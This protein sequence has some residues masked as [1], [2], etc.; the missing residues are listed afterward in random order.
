M[1][2]MFQVVFGRA[3]HDVPLLERMRAMQLH[4]IVAFPEGIDKYGEIMQ[5]SARWFK[6]YDPDRTRTF[7]NLAQNARDDQVIFMAA[8]N[9]EQMEI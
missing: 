4:G 3:H 7:S 8:R 5:P 9:R 1:Q 6:L 2:K